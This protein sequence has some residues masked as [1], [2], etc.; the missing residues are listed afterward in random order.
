MSGIGLKVRA[1]FQKG[2]DIRDAGLTTPD[3]VERTDDILYGE[4]P[5][6][7]VLDL[8]RPKNRTG[9]KL[10]VIV[11]I[12]GGG[13]VYGDK[14]RYQYYCMSL[15]EH[16]FAVVNFTYRLAPEFQFPAAL[17]DTNLVAA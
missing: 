7:Q 13:W 8:Y 1:E 17:E 16:G 5:K 2:D 6:W 11:S 15:V 14:E 10:P 9:E 4:D 12:H 3:F